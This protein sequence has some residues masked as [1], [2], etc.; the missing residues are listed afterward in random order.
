MLNAV[1]DAAA[2]ERS[3]YQMTLGKMIAALDDAHP[4][5]V[6]MFSED[7]FSPNYL[8][9]YRGYYSDL[10]VTAKDA[11]MTVAKFR[12]LLIK[13]NGRTFT[14]YKG[15]DF[16]MTDKT[17]LWRDEYGCASGNAIM[18]VTKKDGSVVLVTQ[19]VDD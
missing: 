7:G 17:P 12:A 9:S 11:P 15:G 5:A 1:I 4:S 6:V 13:A 2:Q 16:V 19:R 8:G 18:A 3:K 14:G 10:M